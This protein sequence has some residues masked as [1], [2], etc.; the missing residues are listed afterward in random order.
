MAAKKTAEATQV[1]LG[2]RDLGLGDEGDDVKV[3]Q[4]LVLVEETGTFD[5]ATEKAV[6]VWQKAH[7]RQPTG[8]IDSGQWK[9]VRQL[10]ESA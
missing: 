5:E 4:A 10:T 3:I 9:L 8:R 2:S 7:S 1:E 6:K